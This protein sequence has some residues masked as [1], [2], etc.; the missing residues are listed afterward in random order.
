[1]KFRSIIFAGFL[2]LGVIGCGESHAEVSLPTIMCG[3]CEQTI[4]S[5]LNDLDGI[6][7]VKIDLENKVGAITFDNQKVD[8]DGIEKAIATLGYQANDT[9]ADPAAYETLPKCC[10]VSS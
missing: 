5:S 10:K 9:K 7:N 6:K 8:L 3:M 2:F 1:M 4:K